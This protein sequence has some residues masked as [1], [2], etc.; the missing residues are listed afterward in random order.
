M[1]EISLATEAKVDSSQFDNLVESS[2]YGMDLRESILLNSA[3]QSSPES[4]RRTDA[5]KSLEVYSRIFRGDPPEATHLAA[6]LRTE[7]QVVNDT[8]RRA[9]NEHRPEAFMLLA[10]NIPADNPNGV[11]VSN[12]LEQ[13]R[14]HLGLRPDLRS[15]TASAGGNVTST[16]NTDTQADRKSD[17]S[18]AE[19]REYHRKT[20]L[21]APEDMTSSSTELD[22]SFRIPKKQKRKASTDESSLGVAVR[23]ENIGIYRPSP[24]DRVVERYSLQY[25][26][27][28]QAGLKGIEEADYIP[29]SFLNERYTDQPPRA[30]ELHHSY[31][32]LERLIIGDISTNENWKNLVLH[33]EAIGL[34]MLKL[35]PTSPLVWT[36]LSET[37]D[38]IWHRPGTFSFRVYD[39]D[40]VWTL[41]CYEDDFGPQ[42]LH[43]DRDLC[44]KYP[45]APRHLNRLM[46]QHYPTE[47]CL[48]LTDEERKTMSAPFLERAKGKGR[49][50]H[51]SSGGNYSSSSRNFRKG[52]GSK[53][54]APSIPLVEMQNYTPLHGK[55]FNL[56]T[57][58]IDTRR[59][60]QVC[61][62]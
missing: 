13:V 61:E 7:P 23:Y 10:N 60:V 40:T 42:T 19:E 17:K 53:G 35:V 57:K 9:L 6:S 1:V 36:V 55:Y 2:V 12:L 51:H 32:F 52:K 30:L 3:D 50:G 28:A 56:K 41:H 27:N 16:G 46:V 45:A 29:S 37:Y 20:V 24:E 8:I 38:D 48:A 62:D 4:A 26:S 31:W 49:G 5:Q 33:F 58:R 15:P 44:I 59:V 25:N 18:A 14:D 22:G 54:S 47:L 43:H 11:D 21:N 34:D 39:R